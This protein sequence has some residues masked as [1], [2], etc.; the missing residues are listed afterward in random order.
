MNLFSTIPNILTVSRIFL[1]PF[2]ALGFFFDSRLGIFLSLIVF[3]FCC[4]TDYLD[5]YYAR[6]YKQ[7]SKL[8]QAL[9][10]LAD[11]VLVS[12]SILFIVGFGLVSKISVIPASIVICREI[13]ISGV[14]DGVLAN[15]GVFST[16]MIAKWKTLTQMLAIILIL[17]ASVVESSKMKLWGEW[18][19]W[20]SSVIAVASGVMYYRNYVS[21]G[22]I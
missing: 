13:I 6:A 20:A 7:T 12:V 19:L 1:L 14:R 16:S 5:G 21:Q 2:F 3:L 17:A 15:Q 9:D 10:P 18:A 22:K 11:K 8:G 4:L